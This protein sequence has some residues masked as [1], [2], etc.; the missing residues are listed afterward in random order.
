[1]GTDQKSGPLAMLAVMLFVMVLFIAII[2]NVIQQMH[3]QWYNQ[4]KHK[5]GIENQ[6]QKQEG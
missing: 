4:V 6:N 5:F 3:H 2:L 1:M